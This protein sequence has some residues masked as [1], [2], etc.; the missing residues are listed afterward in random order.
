MP[1]TF[2]YLST[3]AML[4]FDDV[5]VTVLIL[6]AELVNFTLSLTVFP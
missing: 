2:P 1:L 4:G 3:L 6:E 5:N